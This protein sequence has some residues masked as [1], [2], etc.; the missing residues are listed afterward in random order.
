MAAPLE[1]LHLV[2][3]SP[4]AQG[5]RRALVIERQVLANLIALLKA[6]GIDPLGIH[7]DADLLGA[8]QPRA[9]WLE[10]RW[11]SGGHGGPWLVASPQAVEVLVGQLPPMARQA[12][13]AVAGQTLYNQT[14]DSAFHTFIQGRAQ[15]LDLRQGPFRRRRSVVP[16]PSLAGGALLAFAMVCLAEHLRVEWLS[17]RTA[18]LHA[19]NLQ[20]FLRW[21]PGQSVA[22]DLATQIRALDF[23]PREKTTVEGLVSFTEQLVETGNITV[24]RAVS[25]PSEGWRLEV[26]AQGFDDLE[27][28]RQRAPAVLMDQARQAEQGVRATLTFR[29]TR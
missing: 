6:Q 1:T 23:R 17:K 13:P 28:L 11:L 12:E 5:H 26:L 21:A 22:G 20:A 10:G 18:Q 4:D 16:W 27:R 3:G 19:E 8:D 15:A 24:E 29:E 14:V 7:A 2:F 25:S 9:L